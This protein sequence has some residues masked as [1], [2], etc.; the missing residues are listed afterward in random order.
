RQ[1]HELAQE[2]G[3]GPAR[4]GAARRIRPAGAAEAPD[5]SEP[6]QLTLL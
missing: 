5:P 4:A 6:T 2:Y 1:V 3:I